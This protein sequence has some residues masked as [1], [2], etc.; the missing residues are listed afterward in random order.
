MLDG[1]VLRGAFVGPSEAKAILGL[2]NLAFT[3]PRRDTM[4]PNLYELY[5]TEMEAHF[6][7]AMV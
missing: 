5:T 4:R 3:Q 6:G 1:L 2:G 7:A